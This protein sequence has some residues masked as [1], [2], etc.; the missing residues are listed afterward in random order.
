GL[1]YALGGASL[2]AA[3][4]FPG[5]PSVGQQVQLYLSAHTPAANDLFAFW[6]GANDFFSSSQSNP[7]GTPIDP[8]QP[9]LELVNEVSTLVNAG[10]KQFL[11][12]QAPPLGNVPFFQDLLAA[13]V[14]AQAAVAN[15]NL[16]SAGFNAY[17]S[18]GLAGVKAAHPDVL[19]IQEDTAALFG[20]WTANP[21]AF[22]FTDVT[23]A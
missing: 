11:I 19:I 2:V 10:A 9:A 21:S 8:S 13:H 4:I 17:L 18:A 16:W 1:E 14:I 5:V 23:H 20:Q 3:P 7:S 12:N 15:T 6:A 22:G